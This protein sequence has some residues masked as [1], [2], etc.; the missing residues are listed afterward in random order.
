MTYAGRLITVLDL[1]ACAEGRWEGPSAGG[2]NHFPSWRRNPAYFIR[3]PAVVGGGEDKEAGGQPLDSDSKVVL[4]LSQPDARRQCRGAGEEVAY[5][6]IGMTVALL[7]PGA[8]RSL[9]GPGTLTESKCSSHSG[10]QRAFLLRPFWS[11]LLQT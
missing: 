1:S 6:Q 3:L 4:T 7:R 9:L 11:M 5:N 8:G 2:C 10:M